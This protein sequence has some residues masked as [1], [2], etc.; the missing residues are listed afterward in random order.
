MSHQIQMICLSLGQ[1]LNETREQIKPVVYNNFDILDR[2]KIGDY[3]EG[4]NVSSISTDK[5]VVGKIGGIIQGK[6]EVGPRALGNRSIICDPSFPNMK[7]VLNAKVKFREWFRPF[8]PVCK[9]QHRDVYFEDACESEYMSYAPVV[10]EEYRE[11]LVSITHADATSR[12][13]TVRKDQHKLFY[14][15]LTVLEGVGK[16]PVILNTSFNIK[17]KP[18]LTTY[19]DAFH[20]LKETELGFPCY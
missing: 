10:C 4:Y 12:L 6:S 5:I 13:Q 15:I 3:V 16:I 17:G 18:I 2:D 20:V 11:K 1:Y 9:Y 7:D 19:E 14:D 8:A